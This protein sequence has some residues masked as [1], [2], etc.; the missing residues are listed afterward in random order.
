MKKKMTRKQAKR[1]AQIFA[2]HLSAN[3]LKMLI[4]SLVEE[5][6]FNVSIPCEEEKP[7]YY[8]V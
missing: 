7:A 4:L 2:K 3:E 5:Y 8:V 6:S 1:Y